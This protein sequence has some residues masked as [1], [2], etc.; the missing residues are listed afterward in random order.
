MQVK[1]LIKEIDPDYHRCWYCQRIR[2]KSTMTVRSKVD[3]AVE[4]ID[5][6]ECHEVYIETKR[7]LDGCKNNH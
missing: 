3:G 6:D 4:C 7:Y 1:E 5:E 2:H